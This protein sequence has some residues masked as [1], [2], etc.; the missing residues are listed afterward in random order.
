MLVWQTQGS[1]APRLAPCWVKSIGE[2]NPGG[3]AGTSLRTTNFRD[4]PPDRVRTA[5]MI[6]QN[7]MTPVL[8]R[9]YIFIFTEAAKSTSPLTRC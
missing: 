2:V 4:S 1:L 8:E 9:G 7:D 6:Q 5:A 3:R